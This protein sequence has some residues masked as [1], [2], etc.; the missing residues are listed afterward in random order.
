MQGYKDH[1]D[2]EKYDTNKNKTLVSDP[3]LEFKII[4]RIQNNCPEGTQ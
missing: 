2:L 3:L 1:E 4:L